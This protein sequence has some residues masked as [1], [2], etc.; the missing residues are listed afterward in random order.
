MWT[1]HCYFRNLWSTTAAPRCPSPRESTC[2][3]RAQHDVHF[4]PAVNIPICCLE[5][6]SIWTRKRLLSC[7]GPDTV[8]EA[9]KESHQIAGFCRSFNARHMTPLL[10]DSAR[11]CQGQKSVV[12]SHHFAIVTRE[13]N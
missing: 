9:I 10:Q 6:S 7:S 11:G 8:D 4:T 13:F 2:S 5:I 3:S 1:G 12:S